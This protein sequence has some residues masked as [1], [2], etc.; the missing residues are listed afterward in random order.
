MHR[1]APLAL[2]C[3]TWMNL[4]VHP[5]LADMV[6]ATR[7]IRA[8]TVLTAQDLKLQSGEAVGVASHPDQ[9]VGQETRVAL[10]AGRPVRLEDVG[11]P[12][13]VERN[14]VVELV[15]DHG[16]LRI[17]TEGRSLS[18]AGAGERVRVMNLDSRTTV[19]GRVASDGRVLVSP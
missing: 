18:R 19:T 15:F 5:A 17:T 7:T 2:A 10:Y 1:F 6:V 9:L 12:A 11:P 3:L 16:G 4:Q 14:Q 13:L 8:N